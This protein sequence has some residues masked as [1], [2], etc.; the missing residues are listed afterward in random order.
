MIAARRKIAAIDIA[1]R[2]CDG[3]DAFPQQRACA[4]YKD[5]LHDYE[6]RAKAAERNG[7][8]G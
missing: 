6:R 8:R 7:R 4:E 2:V 5:C 3:C 1:P